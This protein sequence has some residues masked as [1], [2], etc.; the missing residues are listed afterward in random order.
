MSLALSSDEL[1]EL[2]GYKRPT[3]QRAQL[4]VMGIP[5]RDGPIRPL[6]SRATAEA[7]LRGERVLPGHSTGIRSRSDLIR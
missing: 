1:E 7:W 2:T 3:M 6:V 4:D 5:Y